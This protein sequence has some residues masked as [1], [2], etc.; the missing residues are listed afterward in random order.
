VRRYK[1]INILDWC[2][3]LGEE[4]LRS[5]I[6]GFSCPLN[7]EIEQFVSNN[8]LDFAKRKI[9]ITYCVLNMNREIVGIFALAHKAVDIENNGF[10]NSKIKKLNRYATLDADNNSYKASAFLIAQFGKNYAVDDGHSLNGNELMYLTHDVLKEVQ[11]VIGG[12]IV[13]LE[14]EEKT[15]LLEFYQNEQNGFMRFGERYST[16]DNKKYIQLFKFL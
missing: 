16:E 8:A 9:S 4:E 13:Y 15:R 14:C 5:K 2:E 1:I 12:G 7:L 11:H 6:N 3:I 10:S